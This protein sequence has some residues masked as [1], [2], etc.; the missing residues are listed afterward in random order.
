MPEQPSTAKLISQLASSAFLRKSVRVL[1]LHKLANAYL[2]CFPIVKTLPGGITYRA[3]WV[4]S[5]LLGRQMLEGGSMYPPSKLPPNVTRFID[6]GCNVGYFSCWLAHLAGGAPL[7][8]LLVDANGAV[9]QEAQWHAQVNQWSEV[10]AVHGLAGGPSTADGMADFYLYSSN[11]CSSSSPNSKLPGNWKHTK[12]PC[13]NVG[14]L[15]RQRFGDTRCQL[16]KVDIE[17]S[18]KDFFAVDQPF[19]QLVD[20]ILLEWHKWR[21]QLP[22]IEGSLRPRGFGPAEILDENDSAGTCLF[23]RALQ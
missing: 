8:A 19:L 15:W 18:E 2:H 17:G 4:E 11:Y 5:V 3:R 9:V 20:V 22:E 6:L 1:R 14:E 13:V 16:L 7:K 21:V 23:R 10:F 12:V